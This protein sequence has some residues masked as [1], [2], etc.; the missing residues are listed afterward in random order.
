MYVEDEN[1]KNL[2]DKREEEEVKKFR[3]M[4]GDRG[5]H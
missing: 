3:T 1:E 4:S 2:I 5:T